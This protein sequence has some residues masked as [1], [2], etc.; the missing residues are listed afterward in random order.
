MVTAR[1]DSAVQDLV[2]AHPDTSAAGSTAALLLARDGHRVTLVDRDDLRPAPDVESAAATAFRATAPQIVQPHVVLA[3][4]RTLLRQ[5]LPDVYSSMIEAGAVEAALN[6]QMPDTL[7]DHASVP[8]DD[9]LTLVMTRRATVDWVLERS[10]AAEPGV[11]VRHGVRVTGL[12]AED[13]KPPASAVY[14]PSAGRSSVTS[15][16]TPPAV[17]RQ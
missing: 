16:S 9:D 13:D 7:N 3:T 2:D 4:C 1:K 11:D 12:V 6:T 15:S 5:R 10:V 17:A 14:R 8:G